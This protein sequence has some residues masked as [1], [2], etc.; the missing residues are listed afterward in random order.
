MNEYRLPES[1][2]LP[3]HRKSYNS[4]RRPSKEMVP[5]A[6]DS[7][8]APSK[9]DNAWVVRCHGLGTTSFWL[10]DFW[11]QRTVIVFEY[12]PQRDW[13]ANRRGPPE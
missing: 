13:V 2:L 1:V 6:V 8:P 9:G 4:A 10:H 7:G 11:H 3:R 12:N 5:A